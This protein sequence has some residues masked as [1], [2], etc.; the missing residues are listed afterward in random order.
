M[1]DNTEVH[2]NSEA[3]LNKKRKI[4][5][6]LEK[7]DNGTYKKIKKNNKSIVW[8]CF[9]GINNEKGESLDYVFCE[10]CAK[11]L[12]YN[13]RTT[14][15]LLLHPC[16]KKIAKDL[17]KVDPEDKKK[18][19]YSCTGWTILNLVPFT[20]INSKGFENV[21]QNLIDI[22][23][24]YGSK[25]DIKD[26]M[27][28]R[29]TVSKNV[30]TL[31]N[32]F[33]PSIKEDIR[34][35][36]AGSITSDLWS[37][38][39]KRLAYIS[40]TVHYFQNDTLIDRTIAVKHMDYDRQTGENI[41]AK[42]T[43]IVEFYG[44]EMNK[45]VYVT[46]RGSNFKVALK[47]FDQINCS[48]HI[49]N[50]VLNAA[51][52]ESAEFKNMLSKCKSLVK[53][54]KKSTNLQWKL[55]TT[56]KAASETRWN[57]NLAMFSSIKENYTEVCQVLQNKNLMEKLDGIRLNSLNESI[58][59]LENFQFVLEELQAS[60]KPTLYLCIP[61]Y[62]KLISACDLSGNE[63][64]MLKEFKQNICKRLIETWKPLLQINHLAATFLYP[65]CK[66]L[67]MFSPEKRKE[68][69]DHIATIS[70][71]LS[72]VDTL[73]E[74]ENAPDA[75]PIFG[76]FLQEEESQIESIEGK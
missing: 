57:S 23:E 75:D 15:N 46:D 33:L 37:D 67:P 62:Y 61:F 16:T 32:H 38:Q 60:S 58:T 20:T 17:V 2:N 26:L 11:V 74:I 49:L 56:L 8:Q 31:Y 36:D 18:L 63:S 41:L 30:I 54:F 52:K 6:I 5:D 28:C 50:N 76:I 51:T 48:A 44:S 39:F 43:E 42:L 21:S 72:G 13:A 12:V 73:P 9:V 40:V 1:S 71:R 35:I 14:S 25:V 7:I 69:R 66:K 45:F 22:G 34:N 47:D 27:P 68:V 10:K 19:L 24:K 3:I 59:F 4:Q 70:N 65:K 64:P 53:F 29:T 55:Q